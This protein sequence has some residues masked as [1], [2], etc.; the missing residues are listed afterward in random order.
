MKPMW[1]RVAA[2]V[3]VAA[4][5]SGLNP[6]DFQRV[7]TVSGPSAFRVLWNVTATSITVGL[8]ARTTGWVGMGVGEAGSGSMAGADIAICSNHGGTV[9]VADYFATAFAPPT[10][11]GQ[12]DWVLLASSVS[13]T[14][15][16][17]VITRPLD[18]LEVFADRA[19][20]NNGHPTKLI[21]AHGSTVDSATPTFNWYHA[22]NRWTQAINLFSTVTPLGEL[23]SSPD[24]SGHTILVSTNNYVI[25]TIGTYDSATTY[26]DT[27]V[28]VP[29]GT[30]ASVFGLAAEIDSRSAQYVHHLTLKGYPQPNCGGGG[31]LFW[32]WTPGNLPVAMP[33]GV[34]FPVG[35]S[36]GA[37][38]A[39][40]S[41]KLNSHF[42]NPNN[43]ANVQD[44]SGIRLYL[45]NNGT[46]RPVEAG[47]IE[48]GDGDIQLHNGPDRYIAPGITR[49]DF[50]CGST[51]TSAWPH[52]ITVMS[53]FLH[54]HEIGVKQ[55][56]LV[57]RAG[58]DVFHAEVEFYQFSMQSPVGRPGG[59]T[60]R[61]GDSLNTSCY[62][63][64]SGSAT[65]REWGLASQDEM[66]IDF[67][68][69]YPRLAGVTRCGGPNQG[70]EYLGWESVSAVP[71]DFGGPQALLVPSTTAAP[72]SAGPTSA[73]V[74]STP[75]GPPT[76]AAPV[77]PTPTGTP[78]TVSPTDAPSSA[79]P[80][81]P[82]AAPTIAPTQ[83]L[84]D[85]ASG[86]SESGG[87]VII[88]GVVCAVVV[89]LAVLGVVVVTKKRATR[90]ASAAPLQSTITS[91]FVA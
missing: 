18:T 66:C 9:S 49:H 71:K 77:T 29:A 21:F 38:H 65:S 40:Q 17:C 27:C 44:S 3:A 6:A 51:V 90:R 82:T 56:T 76:T 74:T 45:T 89:L 81:S 63:S 84:S 68:T 16:E 4:R 2:V 32:A 31:S 28:N 26:L 54:M 22:A 46:H 41:F 83:L 39:F 36:Y 48:L 15:M 91:P 33:V 34:G 13:A 57:T 50:R 30:N 86:G 60:I 25:P 87:P 85:A 35:S 52:D 59:Y 5:A 42:D 19:I 55:E 75:T 24:F 10:R 47:V 1:L 64:H 88:V 11:D 58:A 73:P 62:Y 43:V 67:V 53:H 12:Q 23:T 8:E 20:V 70:G 7:H 80:T 37:T 79:A 78:T 69:Y 72:V 61:R 14:S